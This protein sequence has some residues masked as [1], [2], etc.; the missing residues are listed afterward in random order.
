MSALN[1]EIISVEGIIFRGECLM[2]VVPSI[3]GDL[4]IMQNHEAVMAKLKAGVV[5]VFDNSQN[6]IKQI[7]IAGGYAEM[8]GADKLIIL[9]D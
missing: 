1:I 9:I 2:A 3:E 6:V 5:K 4:G 7:E 8:A